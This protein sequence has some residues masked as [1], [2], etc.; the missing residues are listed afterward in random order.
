MVELERSLSL[1]QI[2]LMSI[3][4]ILGAGIYV[5]IGEAAG[6]AGNMLWLSFIL[7]AVVASF[8]GLSYVELASR[9]PTAAAEYTYVEHSF[10][11]RFAWI[12]GWMII[13]GS[14]IGGATVALGFARYLSAIVHT[15]VIATAFVA[16]LIIGFVLFLGVQE[17]AS[18][19]II[20]TII[21]AAGLIIVIFVGLPSF[22]AVDYT[23]MAQGIKGLLQAGVL[24]F[25]GYIGFEGITRL[26]NETKQPEKTIPKAILISLIVT[27]ILYILVGLAA[28]SV[29]SFSDLASSN[30]PLSLVAQQ[31][32]GEKSFLALSVI[33]LF[34]TFNTSLAM[35][36]SGSR[37]VYGMAKEKGLPTVFTK[38]SKKT[39][40][41]W[42]AIIGVVLASLLFLFVGDVAVVANLTNFTIF[43]VFIVVNATVIYFRYKKPTDKGFK[44]PG[45]IG[46]LPILPVLGII[47]TL[48]LLFNVSIPVII[49]GSVLLVLGFV[50][51]HVLSSKEMFKQNS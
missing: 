6:L 45:S 39:K 8:T 43:V 41:P 13:A 33:A 9:F 21:E 3:G 40:T 20:F 2:T 32:F 36:L 26:A 24:I 42:V 47:T 30:A 17:T 4:V 15:P 12:T 46:K 44:T 18:L 27:T 48:F 50:L 25:F 34:S 1:W 11:K 19:T 7:A 37:L 16:L 14:I 31:W 5:V 29:V 23:Q 22:G 35:L 51:F 10:G 28:V 38:V 49:M